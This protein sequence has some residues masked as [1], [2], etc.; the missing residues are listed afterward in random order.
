MSH[1]H[2]RL[3][4]LAG[5]ALLTAALLG[6][7]ACKLDSAVYA[8]GNYSLTYD[9]L[10]R[11]YFNDELIAEIDPAQGGTL[12]LGEWEVEYDEFCSDPDFSCPSEAY[13]DEVAIYQPLGYENALLNVVNIGAIGEPGQ[14]L[15]G[16][17]DEG[18]QFDLLLGLSASADE[19]CLAVGLST[20]DGTFDRSPNGRQQR[21]DIIDAATIQITYAAGCEVVEGVTVSSAVRFETDFTGLRTGDVDLG[22]VEPDPAID[23][24]GEE[25]DD[26]VEE[27]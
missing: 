24:N 14:R 9:D 13:W 25:V 3:A 5:A 10:V 16:T 17:V 27:L 12:Q 6:G 2:D 15:A 21:F 7:T 20:A 18:G 19:N 11:V 1:T 4:T 22:D 8:E 23:E 26:N